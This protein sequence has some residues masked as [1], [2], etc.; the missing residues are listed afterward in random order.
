M[1]SKNP[2]ILDSFMDMMLYKED[3]AYFLSEKAIKLI[4]YDENYHKAIHIIN[5]GL[6]IN[7]PNRNFQFYKLRGEC[8]FEIDKN[9]DCAQKLY[10]FRNLILN[11]M[12][13][14][15][16]IENEI[17]AGIRYRYESED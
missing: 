3:P 8:K 9:S 4:V 2:D 6:R 10:F 5:M 12:Q 15:I 11:P 7:D 17:K 14:P 13:T 1:S 16:Q